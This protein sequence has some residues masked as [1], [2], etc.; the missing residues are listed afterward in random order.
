VN[1]IDSEDHP[2]GE[3]RPFSKR[4][5]LSPL[6]GIGQVMFQ[7]SA[8]TGL[9]FLLGIAV[10]S[11][12]TAGGALVAALVGT[13]CAI[14]CRFDRDEI[15]DGIYGFNASLVG[16]A[17]LFRFQPNALAW[18]L[19]IL[20][21]IASTLLT[22]LMRRRVPFPTY[23]APFIIVTWVIFF[24][25]LQ[26]HV[27]T[28]AAAPPGEENAHLNFATAVFTGISEVMFQ[29]NILTGILFLIGILLCSP[30]MAG[31]AMIGSVVGLIAGI[32]EHVPGSALGQGLYGY[33]GALAAMG[34]A[35]YRP[36]LLLPV[37]A[38]SLS[39]PITDRFPQLGLAPLTAPFVVSCWLT[40]ALDQLDQ[41]IYHRRVPQNHEEKTNAAS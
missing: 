27:A 2:V 17:V 30:E 26:I 22:Y 6:T 5:W 19:I 7:N 3:Q 8:V 11:P 12:V 25:A 29:A 4:I 31:W 16:I 21:S 24:I 37:V 33:N 9:F 20:G 32:T 28:V 38:A 14:V 41:A 18:G 10:A 36:S 15:E 39:A 23:T 35:L 1:Q 40:I 13:L 34:M